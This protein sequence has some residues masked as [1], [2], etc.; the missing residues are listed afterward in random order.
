MVYKFLE[1]GVNNSLLLNGCE[2][3]DFTFLFIGHKLGFKIVR[4]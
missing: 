2:P 1:L 3:I 4:K